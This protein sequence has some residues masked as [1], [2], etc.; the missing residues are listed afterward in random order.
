[1]TSEEVQTASS[2]SS[3]LAANEHAALVLVEAAI[4]GLEDLAA[5]LTLEAAALDEA[6][7]RAPHNPSTG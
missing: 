7:A 1:M 6:L 2:P 3:H 4:A 5:G